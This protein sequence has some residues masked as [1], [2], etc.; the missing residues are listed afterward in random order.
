MRTTKQTTRPDC[1]HSGLIELDPVEV[2]RMIEE[3][4]ARLIDVREADERRRCSI[5]GSDALPLGECRVDRVDCD[6]GPMPVFHCH[7][8]GRSL[9]ALQRMHA[10]GKT[11][12][13][14]MRGGIDAWKA[15]GLPVIEDKRA[16][17]SAM[18]Q[19]Q[20]LMGVLVLVG[21]ALGAF[22]SPWALALSGFIGCGMI[23]AGITG[24]CAMANLLG[25]L[26]W[27]RNTPPQE[28]CS[29]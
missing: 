16:M 23:F 1:P 28:S 19:T 27:N 4:K 7:R 26:P 5:V 2:R 3:G 12:V 13:A 9:K 18:Q 22:W 25:S 15:A 10:A 21:V 20:I 24:N 14:H 29:I 11:R 6:I 17:L 8:G